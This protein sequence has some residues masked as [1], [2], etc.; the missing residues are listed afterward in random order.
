MRLALLTQREHGHLSQQWNLLVHA[1]GLG[2]WRR[3]GGVR[4]QRRHAARRGPLQGR[5]LH[6]STFQLNLSRL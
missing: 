6:S 5:G 2:T 1:P 3:R 4:V